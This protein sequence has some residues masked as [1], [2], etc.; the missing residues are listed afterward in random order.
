MG[1]QFSVLGFSLHVKATHRVS[2][3]C[4]LG[5]L[6]PIFQALINMVMRITWQ[7]RE[8]ALR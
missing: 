1:R 6:H 5:Q 2:H 3:F 4:H 7:N 8:V